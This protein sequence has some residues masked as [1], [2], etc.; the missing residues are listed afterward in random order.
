MTPSEELVFKLCRQ[1]F[2]SLWSYANPI[3]DSGKELCDVLVVCEP[4]VLI[5]SVKEIGAKSSGDVE[6]DWAR[7]TRRAIED[8]AKQIYGAERWLG[9]ASHVVRKEGTQGLPLP[10]PERR[11]VHRIAVALGS[12]GTIPIA[13]QDFGKGY[14]H[15]F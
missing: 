5:F 10:A 2:L 8:S 11:R 1:S 14:V 9:S 6:G 13:S 12:G 4:D 7:W 15:V 3:N